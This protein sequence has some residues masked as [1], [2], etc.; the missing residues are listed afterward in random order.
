MPDVDFDNMA[1]SSGVLFLYHPTVNIEEISDMSLSFTSSN[2]LLRYFS[3]AAGL[4]YDLRSRLIKESLAAWERR[5]GSVISV[6]SV[7]SSLFDMMLGAISLSILSLDAT[8]GKL[9]MESMMSDVR[10]SR[11]YFRS[12]F[13]KNS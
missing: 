1:S 13:S 2:S 11:V 7:R 12:V 4:L 9:N 5:S 8:V 10:F 3:I 6:K